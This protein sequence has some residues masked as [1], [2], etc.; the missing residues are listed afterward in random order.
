MNVLQKCNT[1]LLE[2]LAALA[3]NHRNQRLKECKICTSL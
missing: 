2:V 3:Q 1:I